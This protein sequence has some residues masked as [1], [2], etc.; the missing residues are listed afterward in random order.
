MEV[1]L[2]QQ[3]KT[4]LLSALKKACNTGAIEV[5]KYIDTTFKNKYI[6][7][8]PTQKQE[9]TLL[10]G[11]VTGRGTSEGGRFIKEKGFVYFREAIRQEKPTVRGRSGNKK[12]LWGDVK[13]INRKSGF[14]WKTRW[15][16]QNRYSEW[17]DTS[18]STVP[19]NMTRIWE[20]G[21]MFRVVPRGVTYSSKTGESG[22]KKLTQKNLHPAPGW[23]TKQV[24]KNIPNFRM[25]L[26]SR[27]SPMLEKQ[28]ATVVKRSA[29][30]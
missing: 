18:T 6:A 4:K 21:A 8:S 12:V 10:S 16:G 17:R 30:L 26:H 20:N 23:M 9:R 14:G 13:R 24:Y 5:S 1:I 25:M 27:T 15:V 28:L 2:T 3:G 22:S 19:W 29:K 11:D 7:N